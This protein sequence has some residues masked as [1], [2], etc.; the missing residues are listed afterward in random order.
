MLLNSLTHIPQTGVLDRKRGSRAELAQAELPRGK[1]VRVEI[2]ARD[3]MTMTM[4]LMATAQ[5]AACTEME[6]AYSMTTAN[7]QHKHHKKQDSAIQEQT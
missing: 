3:L 4:T 5:A 7:T 2:T 6:W 1:R